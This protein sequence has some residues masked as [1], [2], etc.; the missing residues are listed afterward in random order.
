MIN[1]L[2]LTSQNVGTMKI[3]SFFVAH[4]WFFTFYFSHSTIFNSVW[5][6]DILLAV[7][8]CLELFSNTS[9]FS[10][11]KQFDEQ[12]DQVAVEQILRVV[13]LDPERSSPVSIDISSLHLYRDFQFAFVFE[14]SFVIIALYLFSFSPPFL[15]LFIYISVTLLFG[16]WYQLFLC[17]CV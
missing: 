14:P 4:A 5:Y 13:F 8:S 3:W 15:H 10:P 7:G 12:K 9:I 11:W 6:E 1:T 16:N 2:S 17:W